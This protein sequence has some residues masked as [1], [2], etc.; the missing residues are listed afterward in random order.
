MN[1]KLEF[2]K[3]LKAEKVACPALLAAQLMPLARK[4]ARLALIQCNEP[5]TDQRE[6]AVQDLEAKIQSICRETKGISGVEINRDPRGAVVKVFVPSGKSNS[7]G[8]E[9]ICV[10]Q[11]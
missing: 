9:G 4:M 6:K 2:I 11:N 1:A 5:W 10:P 8:G 3:L 7:F